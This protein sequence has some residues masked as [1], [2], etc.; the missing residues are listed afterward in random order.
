MA[1]YLSKTQFSLATL[2]PN[3]HWQYQS[4]I[5]V[6]N[7]KAK[8][9]LAISKAQLAL[10]LLKTRANYL[11]LFYQKPKVTKYSAKYYIIIILK[12]IITILHAHGIY[13]LSILKTHGNHLVKAHGK[14]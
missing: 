3:S 6:G 14:L 1:I 8:F 7:I 4:P 9:S 5:F 2:K 12:H 13:E 11:A 10:A